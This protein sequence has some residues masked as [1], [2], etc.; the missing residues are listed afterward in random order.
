M[1]IRAMYCFSAHTATTVSLCVFTHTVLPK[2]G[3]TQCYWHKCWF[4]FYFNE[5]ITNW[6][7]S[8]QTFIPL[9]ETS[10]YVNFITELR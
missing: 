9:H 2:D 5:T 1:Q 7:Q 10:K 4:N 6:N 8:N 3:D